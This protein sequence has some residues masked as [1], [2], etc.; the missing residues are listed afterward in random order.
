MNITIKQSGFS[1]IELMVS[2]I[3]VI[4]LSSIAYPSYEHLIQKN[5]RLQIKFNMRQL[6]T[7]IIQNQIVRSSAPNPQE[8][9]SKY[10]TIS[11]K[12]DANDTRI[13]AT[14]IMKHNGDDCH[15]LEL[16]VN[17][18]RNPSPSKCWN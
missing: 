18:T 3:I 17:D 10:Y 16:W 12:T 8:F 1:L 7:K 2:C 11:L 9:S 15:T 14:P 13:I 6:Q 5:N 4:I